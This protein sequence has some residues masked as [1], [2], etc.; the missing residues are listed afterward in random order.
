MESRSD[1]HSVTARVSELRQ[2]GGAA[3]PAASEQLAVRQFPTD[4]AQEI[5]VRTARLADTTEVEDE[6][7]ID[8]GGHCPT[9]Q[10]DW[11]VAL[12]RCSRPRHRT[13][14][15]DVETEDDM[16][17]ANLADDGRQILERCECLEPDHH[18]RNALVAHA[19]RRADG[20][21]SRIHQHGQSRREHPAEVLRRG[22][23]TGDCVQ[24]GD[25]YFREPDPVAVCTRQRGR[26]PHL[27]R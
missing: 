23:V 25:I 24:I 15:A 10:Q 6:H 21:G 13:T 11:R 16:G 19:L 22:R 12:E 27:L 18:A 2:V 26:V 3:N 9:R 8:A 4:G 20:R 14:L 17:R 5:D 1:Q 7:R